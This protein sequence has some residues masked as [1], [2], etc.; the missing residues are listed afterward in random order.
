V[1]VIH[2]LLV[3]N[4]EAL[5]IKLAVVDRWPLFRGGRC[6]EVAVN[7]GLTVNNTTTNSFLLIS[8]LC[9][10]LT[11]EKCILEYGND[12]ENL[13]LKECFWDPE[14]EQFRCYVYLNQSITTVQ[15]KESCPKVCSENYWKCNDF[16]IPLTQPCNGEC[17]RYITYECNA[18][19]IPI[20]QPCE[21]SCYY[22]W[23]INCYG[24]CFDT[25]NEKEL[26]IKC[27]GE[28]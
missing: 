4:F 16:C 23:Q 8:E 19:C 26:I 6:S 24:K 9:Y 20:N 21:G 14:Y 12:T 13:D 2:S 27:S 25:I 10:S 22:D 15:C 3:K 18:I 28:R 7:T 1:V 11:N 17:M 5:G